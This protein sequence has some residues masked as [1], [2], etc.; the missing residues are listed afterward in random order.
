MEFIKALQKSL[1][2]HAEREAFCINNVF[3]TY[4]DFN[5]EISKIRVA[6]QNNT[7]KTD[8]LIGLVTNDDIYT[9]ASIVALWLEG[10]AYVPVNPEVPLD[11]NTHI[12]QSINT[13]F[14]IDSSKISNYNNLNLTVINPTEGEIP[15]KINLCPVANIHSEDLA[16][17]LFTSG[18]TGV[19]KGVSITFKNVNGFVNA[20]NEDPGF[21][22]M[23]TDKCLQMF[24]LTFD[25][26]V[27]SY[28]MPLLSGASIYTI[29]SK[30]IKYFQV[31][32][33]LKE[34]KLTVLT[35]VA[36]IIHYLRPYFK[37]INETQVRY[38]SFAGG[39]L[40]DDIASEWSDCIPNSKIYNYYG[41]TETTIYSGFYLYE[42]QNN[43]KAHNGIISIGKPMGDLKYMVVN[44]N[45]EEVPLKTTGELCISGSQ[46]TPGYWNNPELNNTV[47]F[48][49]DDNGTPLIYYKTGDLCFKD[50]EGDYLYVGRADFQVKIRGYRVE[51]SEIEFHAKVK[52]PIKVNMVAIDIENNLGNAEL[53]LAIESTPFNTDEIFEYMKT[54]LPNYMIPMHVE[55][56]KEFP[57]SI[58]GKIDRKALRTHFKIN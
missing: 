54:K 1:I 11:R 3:Y 33:L 20:I 55:F 28:L 25:M 26:S 43:T 18:S 52:A 51:L 36:S 2:K 31:Y 49:V 38:C 29:P 17:I 30:A 57:H 42:K 6:I 53:G 41:P 50:H 15:C 12:L 14:I 21:E 39:A 19:P 27:V 56:I 7:K 24:E 8:T 58:N 48:S 22:L 16:Y 5:L 32:K 34:Y 40:H 4:S 10:K 47:F 45:N 44:E 46:V 37:E 9:Y 35:L 13:H 23:P